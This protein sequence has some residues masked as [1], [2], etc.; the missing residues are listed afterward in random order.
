MNPLDRALG[1]WRL[2]VGV[3][4]DHIAPSMPSGLRAGP[5]LPAASSWVGG[6]WA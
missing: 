1:L 2:G 6:G 4:D 3:W 5:C